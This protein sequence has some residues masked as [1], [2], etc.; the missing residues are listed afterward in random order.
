MR[1][2]Q[3]G[4]EQVVFVMKNNTIQQMKVAGILIR[5]SSDALDKKPIVSYELGK[6]ILGL[7]KSVEEYHES[8][9]FT[10]VQDLALEL[11]G[12]KYA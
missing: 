2:K 12:K 5:R 6:N 8:L 11:V 9:V 4:L 1:E 10:D 7:E 3:I